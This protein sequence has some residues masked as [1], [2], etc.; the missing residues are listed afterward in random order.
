MRLISRTLDQL[1]SPITAATRMLAEYAGRRPLLDLSQGSPAYAT[2]PVIAKRIALVARQP[3]GGRY[4]S[5]PGLETL[6]NLLAEEISR[7]YAG[8]VS[9]NN[10]LITAGCNQAFC[11]AVSALADHGDEV[12]LTV[13]YYF[14]HDMW[15]R[16]DR[17]SP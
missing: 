6:R 5:R 7:E 15:L 4:T 10:V 16:L 2:A 14:N 12:I 1:Q 9:A 13:P 11:V 17:L 8:S 3:E